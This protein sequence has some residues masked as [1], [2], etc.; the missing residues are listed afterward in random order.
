MASTSNTLLQFIQLQVFYVHLLAKDISLD[1]RLA[2]WILKGECFHRFVLIF[3]FI[4]SSD[5]WFKKKN[6]II[7]N[8]RNELTEKHEFILPALSTKLI[9][10]ICS[11]ARLLVKRCNS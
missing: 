6:W 3:N 1:Q 10:F 5:T 2:T 9:Y 7:L 8:E 11:R 4:D